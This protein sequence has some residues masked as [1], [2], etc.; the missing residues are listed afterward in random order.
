MSLT[1]WLRAIGIAA[2]SLAGILLVF[3]IVSGRQRRIGIAT[4]AQRRQLNKTIFRL[5]KTLL[6]MPVFG[7]YLKSI[8]EKI[9]MSAAL[10]ENQL[11]YQSLKIFTTAFVLTGIALLFFA[12]F[13][14]SWF[15]WLMAVVVL[16]FV[17]EIISDY[18][19]GRI[20][21]NLLEE[22]VVFID[23]LRTSYFETA[24]IDDAYTYAIDRLDVLKHASIYAHA[25]QI[26][27]TI[28]ATDAELALQ[29]YYQKAPNA[30][31][32][33]LAGLSQIVREYGDAQMATGSSFVKSLTHLSSE[34]KDDIIKRKKLLFGLKAMNVIAI[35]PLFAIEPLKRWAS[36]SFY[37]LK[38]FYE[39]SLGFSL[40]VLVLVIIL[41]CFVLLRH[42]QDYSEFG[43]RQQTHHRFARYL[44]RR[45]KWLLKL[46]MPSPNSKTYQRIVERQRRALIFSKIEYHYIDKLLFA[47]ISFVIVLVVLLSALQINKNNVLVQPTTPEGFLAGE[48]S[49][50][51]LETAR[52]VTAFD[53]R[54]L[55]AGDRQ[56]TEQAL[57]QY[58]TEQHD[59]SGD[60]KQQVMQRI[61]A[62]QDRLTAAQLNF[63]HILIL[64]LFTWLGWLLP[65][66]Y[67]IT[68]AQILKRELD[69]E[70]ARFQL[71]VMVLMPID[72][73][74]VDQVLEW[75]EKFSKLFKVPLQKALMEYDAGAEQAL[76]ELKDASPKADYQTLINHLI[77]SVEALT[78]KEAFHEFES[79]KLYYQDK[80]KLIGHNLVKNKIYLGRVIGFVPLYAL[81]II[82]F[83]FP[84]IY[85]SIGELQTYF[86]KLTF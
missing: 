51:A 13:I 33:L 7:H 84:L 71:L 20:K 72:Q 44:T 83:M 76:L 41:V 22:M 14:K 53:N 66:A 49:G 27:N 35:T 58:I 64:Y 29:R 69:S 36:H 70:I 6:I 8:R 65:E 77:S 60:N 43:E 37:P 62:K 39:G 63:S 54:I 75:F 52:E 2:I 81:L 61:M 18:Y 30:Y 4:S 34:L 28:V 21:L 80:R 5:Y 23:Y 31:L 25:N 1:N 79:E 9:T 59:L 56:W 19:Y 3:Q 50:K 12:S 68:Q 45:F 15:S 26:Y 82:Y 78:I 47:T 48:L 24:V 55:E 38:V 74:T 16:Y 67:L 10:D 85:A 86:D 42:L 11:I 73:M 46:I 57:A 32:K 40:E 17:I